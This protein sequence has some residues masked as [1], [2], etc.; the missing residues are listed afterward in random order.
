YGR[1]IISGAKGGMFE[2]NRAILYE[3]AVKMI[4]EACGYGDVAKLMGG[5]P[6]GY[7]SAAKKFDILE[8][9]STNSDGTISYNACAAM[10]YTACTTPLYDKTYGG[11]T[12]ELYPTDEILIERTMGVKL[13]EGVV[14]SVHGARLYDGYTAEN[15]ELYVGGTKFTLTDDAVDF[16]KSENLGLRVEVFYREKDDDKQAFFVRDMDKRSSDLIISADDFVGYSDY[17]ISY[18]NQNGQMKRV[19]LDK[20]AVYVYNGA[21]EDANISDLY[22][23]FKLGNIILRKVDGAS[24]FNLAIMTSYTNFIVG[25]YGSETKTLVEKDNSV[26]TIDLSKYD[27]MNVY[28]NGAV[29]DELNFSKDDLLTIAK[30]KEAIEIHKTS[31]KETGTVKDISDDGKYKI[32]TIGNKEYQVY[33]DCFAKVEGALKPSGI[34]EF[35][36]DIFGRI[37]YLVIGETVDWTFGY[38]LRGTYIDSAFDGKNVLEI[39]NQKDEFAEYTVA[40]KVN[41]DGVRLDGSQSLLAYFPNTS[42]NTIKMQMIRYKLDAD[43]LI[44]AIDTTAGSEENSI[45]KVGDRDTN[46]YYAPAFGMFVS[47]G[48]DRVLI[49]SNTIVMDIPVIGATYD[50]VADTK[51]FDFGLKTMSQVITGWYPGMVSGY[52]IGDSDYASIV[53]ISPSTEEANRA[54]A[55]MVVEGI[56]DS[57]GENGEMR[58]TIYGYTYSGGAIQYPIYDNAVG[59]SLLDTISQGDIVGL[60]YEVK[61]SENLVKSI[62]LIYDCDNDECVKSWAGYTANTRA[63]YRNAF[64]T[65]K[66]NASFGYVNDINDDVIYLSMEKG[67]DVVEKFNTT[68]AKI[69]VYDK[70]SGK[71][72]FYEGNLSD[73]KDYKNYGDSCSK[74]IIGWTSIL[75]QGMI[76]YK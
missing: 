17:T 70:N 46:K 73:I 66:V 58:K 69:F 31:L 56:G 53:T 6:S 14:D 32:L 9:V 64:D 48:N 47:S 62:E 23:S 19:A 34:C 26:N 7:I 33:K 2:P 8:S 18:Y 55:A 13:F 44:K 67:G 3:E 39:Y 68:K 72:K 1:G 24:A 50:D 4:V 45:K 76:V 29:V 37:A 42:G 75:P 71:V 40:E 65:G 10:L 49:D 74:V 22:K 59:V 35:K 27:F 36:T 28:E 30:N 51:E 54:N 20:G 5:Y 57:V 38:L 43:G 16:Q 61:N 11:E 21:N 25:A 60:K 41:F 52:V 15:G 12:T 63:W